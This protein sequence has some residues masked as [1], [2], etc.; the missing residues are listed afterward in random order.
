MPVRKGNEFNRQVRSIAFA[1]VNIKHE[2]KTEA[3]LHTADHNYYIRFLVT[4]D[5]NRNYTGN[6]GDETVITTKLPLGDFV[7]NIYP[8]REDLTLTLIITTVGLKYDMKYKAVI[9][10]VAKEVKSGSYNSTPLHELNKQDYTPVTFQLLNNAV[11]GYRRANVIGGVYK[12][13]PVEFPMFTETMMALGTISFF[14][15]TSIGSI[16]V[17]TPNN[18]R[19]YRQIIIPHDTK[20]KDVPVLM[21]A[22]Y[23]VYNGGITTYVQNYDGNNILFVYPPYRTDGSGFFKRRLNIYVT[24]NLEVGALSNTYTLTDDTINVLGVIFGTKGTGQLSK[25]VSDYTRAVG[26][27]I[28]AANTETMAQRPVKVSPKA[29]KPDSSKQMVESGASG[30]SASE[31]SNTVNAGR[32]TNF[33]ALRS[34]ILQNAGRV[35][36]MQWQF[37]NARYLTPGMAVDVNFR[38]EK[39]IDKFAGILHGVHISYENNKKMEVAQIAVFFSKKSSIWNFL[40]STGFF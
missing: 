1:G 5:I 32:T 19:F 2:H 8:Q 14:G 26:N 35:L 3:V 29:I 25:S 22:E 9:S 20:A 12:K 23:G 28:K 37:S 30:T 17:A 4:T 6:L 16:E 40:G 38:T 31:A 15:G 18:W 10:S 13:C 7:Y 27:A 11:E 36:H 39:G 21:Q 34:V 24:N 33:F